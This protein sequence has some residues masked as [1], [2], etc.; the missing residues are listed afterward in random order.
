MWRWWSDEGWVY[1]SLENSAIIEKSWR[2]KEVNIIINVGGIPFLLNLRHFYQFNFI[3]QRHRRISRDISSAVWLWEDNDGQLNL[4]Q[5]NVSAQIERFYLHIQWSLHKESQNDEND[6][7]AHNESQKSSRG[8][9]SDLPTA[10]NDLVKRPTAGSCV[11]WNQY[12]IYP[13]ECVQINRIT[14]KERKIYRRYLKRVETDISEDNVDSEKDFNLEW[15]FTDTSEPQIQDALSII[16]DTGEFTCEG[17]S[18]A[19]TPQE[20]DSAISKSLETQVDDDCCLCLD[21]LNRDLVQLNKCSHVFHSECLHEMI[22]HLN[23]KTTMFCPLCMTPQCFGRGN[24]PPGK[25]RYIVYKSGNIEI[26]SYPNTNVIEIEYFI[27]SGIQNQRHPSPN[28]PF[29]GTYKIA[30]LPFNKKGLIMLDG[31]AK[32]FQ[33][34]HTFKV[35]NFTNPTTGTSMEVTQ[36]GTIPHKISTCG[37]P[38]LHGFPDPNFFNTL[39]SKLTSLG[40]K[41]KTEETDLPGEN[42]E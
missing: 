21:A 32:A 30:Y 19:F 15:E 16:V 2:N 34:G 18:S 13:I 11:V 25:M 29:T 22:T 7:K 38:A 14:G 31:L 41:C 9:G 5:P 4:Y 27:P 12:D 1:Y 39:I 6:H 20:I 40:I 37:G 23:N 42:Q 35:N 26:E 17:H 36:W 8:P 24:S 3:T 28:K 33:L 10:S